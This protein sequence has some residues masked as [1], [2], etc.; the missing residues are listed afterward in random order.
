MEIYGVNY[1]IQL[2]YEKKYGPENTPYLET[3]HAVELTTFVT[4]F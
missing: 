4:S 2:K 3:Y 1:R